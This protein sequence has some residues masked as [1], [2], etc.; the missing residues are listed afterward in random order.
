M[1]KGGSFFILDDVKNML[2]LKA[3]HFN[4]L[5]SENYN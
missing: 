3:I 1:K 4:P 2:C 5:K